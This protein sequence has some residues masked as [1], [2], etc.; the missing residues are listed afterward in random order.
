MEVKFLSIKL[1]S[2]FNV[3]LAPEKVCRACI[4]SCAESF[5]VLYIH[6][7]RPIVELNGRVNLKPCSSLQKIV[8]VLTRTSENVVLIEHNKQL[9]NGSALAKFEEF[10]SILQQANRIL[11]YF[12]TRRDRIFDFI[13]NL[14]ARY[15]YVEEDAG[16]YYIADV[17]NR[18]IKQGF[19]PKDPVQLSLEI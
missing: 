5:K 18:G 14:A 16:G 2:G 13:A 6:T 1:R 7:N 19:Y 4:R 12:S 8:D 15:I 11:I 17:S 3:L 9:F 10:L